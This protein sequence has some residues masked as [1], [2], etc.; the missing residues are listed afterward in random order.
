LSTQTSPRRVLVPPPTPR[1]HGALARLVALARPAP[2]E[3]LRR[4]VLPAVRFSPRGTG[5]ADARWTGA[6][7]AAGILPWG[8]TSMAGAAARARG[9]GLAPAAKRTS[10][11]RAPASAAGRSSQALALAVTGCHP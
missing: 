8:V 9:V 6:G 5:R 3:R 2:P 7:G 10:Q 1:A 11:P 4:A